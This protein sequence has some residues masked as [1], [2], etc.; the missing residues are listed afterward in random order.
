MKMSID[1][2]MRNAARAAFVGA[3]AAAAYPA[4]AQDAATAAQPQSNSLPASTNDVTLDKV[5]GVKLEKV[6]VT[7]SRIRRVD[8]AKALP[9]AVVDHAQI[10]NS[11]VTTIGDL[12]QELPSIAGNATNPRVNNGGGDGA[13]TISLRG[14]GSQRTL[15]LLNG[16]RMVTGDVNA[17]PINLIERVEVLKEGASA[18][19]GSD[20]VGGV[21]NFITRRD[22]KGLEASADYG[23]SDKGDG[24]RRGASLSYGSNNEKSS[25]M[26]GLNYN[27]Q[28]SVSAGSRDFSKNALYLSSGSIIKG[29]SSRNPR[30]RITLSRA[31]AGG[32]Y[33]CPGT[34]ATVTVSRKAGTD[35]SQ[36]SDYQC[37]NATRDAFNYQAVG[38]VLSTPQER[39]GLFTSGKYSLT[40]AVELYTDMFVNTTRSANIIAP[41]PFDARSDDVVISAQN[42]YNPFGQDFGGIA[43]TN[44]NLLSRFVAL[45]NRTQNFRT[46]TGQ[47]NVGMKGEL[48]SFGSFK[49]WGWDANVGY[50]RIEQDSNRTGYIL[51]SALQ[52]AL[53]PS[54]ALAGGGFGCG[55]AANPINGCTP[56]NI[57][58]LGGDPAQTAAL[59][60][61][62]AN[63]GSS[64][65][66]TQK[67]AALT[68]TGEA[69]QLPAGP[70][71]IATGFEYR[72]EELTE[73]VDFLARALAPDFTTCYL[74]Q[75]VC[76]NATN[77]KF[78]LREYFIEGN[79]PVLANLP[80]VKS[81]NIDL[82]S[83]FSNYSSFGNTT[84]SAIKLEYRPISDVL[85]RGTYAQVFRAPQI[86]D[87]Y[88]PSQ[89]NNPSFNDPC[90]GTTTP[91]GQNPNLDKACQNVPRD[92][93][94][95]EPTSQ[96][97][98]IV[99][100]NSKLK[101]EKGNVY[102][103][104]FVV[105]PSWQYLQGT[106]FS[107]DYFIYKLKDTIEAPAA[108]TIA[109]QCLA[110]GDP[111]YC[112][113]IQR[114]PDGTIAQINAPVLNLGNV[115]SRGV[116]F[117][118]GYRLPKTPIGRFNYRL[119][120]TYVDRFD[121]TPNP[122]DPNSVLHEAGTYSKQ[123]GN[124]SRVRGLSALTWANWG[125]DATFS[126]R[127][128]SSYTVGSTDPNSN[129]G[130]ADGS[131]PG[132]ALKANASWYYDMTAGY[133]LKATKTHFIVG[134]DN[135]SDK[136]PTILYQ[137]NVLNSNVDVN[138]FDTVGRYYFAKIV[139]SF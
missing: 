53:G 125:F 108:D 138:T 51:K 90:T 131:L 139:Q 44:P 76:S 50:G 121:R 92:G 30:G 110:S 13:T 60:A 74:A 6:E 100:G 63:A 10:V 32:Q 25:L 47:F 58:N 62:A 59:Q 27:Q 23:V 119:D 117:S 91:V 61:V 122:S 72:K 86:G 68:F 67:T 3:L 45:G 38:N 19:Y 35:G 71:A 107:V 87:L 88:A 81:L 37:Y 102:T 132:V 16:N 73:Q 85:V 52:A 103:Y 40:D 57:F 5:N 22:Y 99:S 101:P 65:N 133:K 95:A 41:L 31:G 105:D 12:I 66:A 33:N 46:N 75:E 134:V 135:I 124:F 129:L 136:K 93:S 126:T 49:N 42:A 54:Y 70:L 78:D 128:I 29:G 15:I 56:V 55:T 48:P 14:L 98:S 18:I 127:Y 114:N 21:V 4:M 9:I 28:D 104:G 115:D 36:Q 137:N 112:G 7:G 2:Y 20:A 17:I 82:S 69:M 80:G 118:A 84:N 106:T 111:T 113:L 97:T 26:I 123:D 120:L 1:G 43:G 94:F 130:S 89:T 64:S 83:R 34:S 109:R 8:A 79:I 11:G 39:L 116:D 77:G 96:V 24:T